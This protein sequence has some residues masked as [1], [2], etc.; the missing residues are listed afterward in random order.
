MRSLLISSF[1]ALAAVIGIW[2]QA[3][4]G[5]PER[6]PF[7]VAWESN[8]TELDA[9]GRGMATILIR[10][11]EGHYLYQDKCDIEIDQ[12]SAVKITQVVWP[13][14]H[15]KKDTF[16][17]RIVDI[18]EGDQTARVDFKALPGFEGNRD[19]LKGFFVYQGCSSTLCFRQQRVPFTLEILKTG[20]VPLAPG[21]N[22]SFQD[23]ESVLGRAPLLALAAAFGG[24]VLTDFTPCVLPLLPLILG[25]VGLRRGRPLAKNLQIAAGLVLGMAVM[26]TGLGLVAAGIGKSLG[27]LFQSRFFVAFMAL[28][29]VAMALA[30]WGLIPL[31]APSFLRHRAATWG[32]E[33]VGGAFGVGL[34]LGIVAAPCVGPVMAPL[35]LFVAKERDFLFGGALL[36][37]YAMG[38]GT[39]IF[40]IAVAGG[41]LIERLKAGRVVVIVKV[42][43][44]LLLL[45]PAFYYA[46]IVYHQWSSER[47]VTSMPTGSVNWMDTLAEGESLARSSKRPMVIDFYAT[48]C[49]PCIEIDK[50]V[51][52]DP[53]VS[54]S[55]KDF[56]TV[57]INCTEETPECR[58]AVERFDVIG[59][60]TIVFIDHTGKVR[61]DLRIVGRVPP[62]QEFLKTLSALS[63]P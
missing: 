60:P 35:L 44:G 32:G 17:G 43:I 4:A 6:D 11:P 10:A 45:V 26:Y 56:V 34:G 61:D 28:F 37:A 52:N 51:F 53:A 54:A 30:M 29:F 55:L 31:Q 40:L 50:R 14:G 63:G 1:C 41:S 24:G 42:V 57:R 47:A 2:D 18:L 21:G 3:S 15:S 25:F 8:S 36:F 38:M 23:Y 27:F 49:L 62:P 9:S 7:T 46:S 5:D 13:K 12:T 19:S 22:H 16:T 39:L 48:W 58:G 33:G 59:W 20:G